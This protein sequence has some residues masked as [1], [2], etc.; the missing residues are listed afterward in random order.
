MFSEPPLPGFWQ[1]IA[2]MLAMIAW[3]LWGGRIRKA[4]QDLEQRRRDADLQH[5]YDRANPTSHFRQSV[6]QINEDTPAIAP[7]PD[8]PGDFTWNG[9]FYASR[10]DAEAARWMHVLREARSFYQDLDRSFGNRI[11]GRR[12]ASSINRNDNRQD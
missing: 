10:D 9:E 2:L 6:D 5:L 8:R 7:V 12:S 4:I 11:S 3:R 1:F